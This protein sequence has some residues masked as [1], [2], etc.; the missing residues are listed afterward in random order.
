MAAA[1]ERATKVNE[2]V[3]LL[4][5]SDITQSREFYCEGLG[6]EMRSKWDP[7]GELKWCRLQHG[8]AGLMLQAADEED[9]SR[10]GQAGGVT[11]YFI[12]EDADSFY[13]EITDRGTPATPPQLAFY[14]MNQ[15]FIIDPDGYE[16]CFE[17]PEDI[18]S[19]QE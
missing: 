3:P 10:V 7:N 18:G 12:C 5:V 14:K 11:F 8:G 1:Q 4:F 16:L 13:R 2:T 19:G 6:F 17:S 15:T 9:G